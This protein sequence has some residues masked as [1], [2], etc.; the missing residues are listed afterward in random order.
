MVRSPTCP[1][2]GWC[3]MARGKCWV[4]EEIAGIEAMHLVRTIDLDEDGLC[5]RHAR[6]KKAQKPIQS[7]EEFRRAVK[8]RADV[9]NDQ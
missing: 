6:A 1:P 5:H 3:T 8:E 2:D 4:C 7:I 9:S